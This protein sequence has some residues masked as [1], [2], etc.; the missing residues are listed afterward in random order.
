MLVAVGMFLLSLLTVDTP[1]WVLGGFLAVLGVGLGASMQIMVLVVQNSFPVEEVGTATAGNN[2]F[3]QIGA[4]LGSAVVGSVF[5]SR[6]AVLL[7]ERVP[8][9]DITAGGANSL[10]PATVHTLPDAVQQPILES[11]NDALTPIYL[12]I[13]PLAV[14]AAILLCFVVEKP[15]ATTVAR[16]KEPAVTDPATTPSL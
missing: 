13:S 5:A 8:G 11:Y 15:L 3:R 7:T 6:L 1:I 2:Y 14:V 4:T 9:G 16:R 10:T 12:F